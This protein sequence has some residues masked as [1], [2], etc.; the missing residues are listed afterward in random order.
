MMTTDKPY[1]WLMRS[2]YKLRHAQSLCT[3]RPFFWAG[4]EATV[5]DNNEHTH[6]H[7]FSLAVVDTNGRMH[8]HTHIKLSKREVD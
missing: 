2:G 7:N 5:V 6:T 1:P 4:D 8:T 3:T